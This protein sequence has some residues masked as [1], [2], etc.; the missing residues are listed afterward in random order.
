MIKHLILAA[1]MVLVRSEYEADDLIENVD[2]DDD[3]E[4]IIQQEEPEEE[5]EEVVSESAPQEPEEKSPAVEWED[6]FYPG[7]E[8]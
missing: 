3:V 7:P 5:E 1:I 6:P 8:M 2:L 4:Q